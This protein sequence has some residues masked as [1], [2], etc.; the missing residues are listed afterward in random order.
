M[1]SAIGARRRCSRLGRMKSTKLVVG[2]LAVSLLVNAYLLAT[3]SSDNAE[4]GATSTTV[5]RAERRGELPALP[6]AG[7]PSGGTASA[8]DDGETT[9]RDREAALTAELLKSQ[10]ALAKHQSDLDR[11]RQSADRSPALEEQGKAAL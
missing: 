3:R 7:L 5:A 1:M 10:A 9:V 8:Q 4:P 11:L 6:R 2:L